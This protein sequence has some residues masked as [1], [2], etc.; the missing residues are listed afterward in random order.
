MDIIQETT[1]HS[2]EKVKKKAHRCH[3]YMSSL[4]NLETCQECGHQLGSIPENYYN[5][6]AYHRYQLGFY[7]W[8]PMRLKRLFLKKKDFILSYEKKLI[9]RCFYLLNHAEAFIRQEKLWPLV[10]NEINLIITECY[11]Y[12]FSLTRI[13]NIFVLKRPLLECTKVDKVLFSNQN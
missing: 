13:K 4:F 2:N 3:H 12:E 6:H 11:L 9:K 10:E 1:R 8:L 7:R 5:L